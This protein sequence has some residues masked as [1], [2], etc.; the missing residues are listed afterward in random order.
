M[1]IHAELMRFGSLVITRAIVMQDPAQ[2]SWAHHAQAGLR[3]TAFLLRPRCSQRLLQFTSTNRS[4]SYQTKKNTQSS[5]ALGWMACDC[6]LV[7]VGELVLGVNYWS[8]SVFGWSLMDVRYSVGLHERCVPAIHPVAWTSKQW[9]P[10]MCC[11]VCV[12]YHLCEGHLDDHSLLITAGFTEY[13]LFQV[14]WASLGN[15]PGGMA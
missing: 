6:W 5:R 15:Y 3:A 10:P 1:L 4:K 7:I 9:F 11:L 14:R 13:H 2:A 12:C 8:L